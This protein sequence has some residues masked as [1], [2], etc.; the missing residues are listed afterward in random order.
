M[1]LRDIGHAQRDRGL[2]KAIAPRIA[3]QV[4]LASRLGEFGS[5]ANRCAPP[6][7]TFTIGKARDS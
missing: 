7:G 5:R 3:A 6:F 4:A 2:N 1:R